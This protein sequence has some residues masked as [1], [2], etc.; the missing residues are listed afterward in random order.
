[1]C[2][3]VAIAA[4]DGKAADDSN[5]E[6]GMGRKVRGFFDWATWSGVLKIARHSGRAALSERRKAGEEYSQ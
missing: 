6:A 2:I 1:M 3:A 5:E 4:Q